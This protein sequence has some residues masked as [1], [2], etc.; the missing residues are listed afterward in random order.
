MANLTKLGLDWLTKISML[1]NRNQMV[2]PWTSLQGEAA[3]SLLLQLSLQLRLARRDRV[4]YLFIASPSSSELLMMSQRSKARVPLSG[5]LC[6]EW[7]PCRSSKTST[8]GSR[9]P[10]WG[11]R[12]SRDRL[13]SSSN[14][15]RPCIQS[16]KRP[17]VM[18]LTWSEPLQDDQHQF[19]NYNDYFPRQHL[20]EDFSLISIK[21]VWLQK[22]LIVIALFN[23]VTHALLCYVGFH[24]WNQLH[25]HC[26]SGQLSLELQ[27][28]SIR[29]LL[30]ISHNCLSLIMASPLEERIVGQSHSICPN[31]VVGLQ[32]RFLVHFFWY[33][34]R[35]RI[36]CLEEPVIVKAMQLS[37]TAVCVLGTHGEINI[38]SITLIVNLH[39]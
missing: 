2:K 34:I 3:E 25:S 28:H 31:T 24:R 27:S 16:F 5:K 36:L 20:A 33:M 18:T 39:I 9:P 4:T 11:S 7:V 8:R 35:D 21:Q 22:F 13:E 6:L 32:S 23:Y 14:I 12:A 38:G 29:N 17:I 30:V 19:V 26:L 10:S 37:E 1:I 15:S